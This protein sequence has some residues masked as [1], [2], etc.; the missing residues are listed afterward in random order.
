MT[1]PTYRGAPNAFPPIRAVVK[2]EFKPQVG[3]TLRNLHFIAGPDTRDGKALTIGSDDPAKPLTD[4]KVYDCVVQSDGDDGICPAWNYAHGIRLLRVHVLGKYQNEKLDFT[5]TN[6]CF[7]AG[8]DPEKPAPNYPDWLTATDCS[9]MGGYRCPHIRGGIFKFERCYFG[10]SRRNDLTD[11]VGDFVNCDFVTQVGMKTGPGTNNW[12]D[13][14]NGFVRPLC[15]IGQC[16]LYFKGCTLTVL[17]AQGNVIQYG[18]AS[19]PEL[20]RSYPPVGT[21][22]VDWNGDADPSNF[23]GKANRK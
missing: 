18:P 5:R 22:T 10:P 4:V 13:S 17:D 23:V 12:S 6:K 15:L 11:A 7:I 2:G 3:Q 19:G 20:C 14:A 9:F 8:A 16:R 1:T 21:S